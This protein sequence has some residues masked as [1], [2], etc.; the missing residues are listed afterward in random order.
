MGTIGLLK[1]IKK[2]DPELGSS[3]ISFAVPVVVGEIKNYFRDHGWA[4]RCPES[5]RAKK[6]PWT[7]RW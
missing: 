5:F 3:F 1:A 6:W 2:F 4:G 7:G